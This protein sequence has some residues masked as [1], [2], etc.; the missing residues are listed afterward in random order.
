MTAPSTTTGRLRLSGAPR[1]RGRV[2]GEELRAEI[3]SGM[4]RWKATLAAALPIPIDAYLDRFVAETTFLAA[5]EQLTPDLLA[6]VRGIG[7]GADIPFRDIYAYQLMDEEWF[8]RTDLL[9]ERP[10]GAEHCSTLGALRSD[11]TALLAQ[12]MDLPSYYDGTQTLLHL[13]G[14]TAETE[15]MV[16][17]PA[18]LIGTTGC[19]NRGVGVCVNTLGQLAHRRS[20][21]PVA[22]VM[23]LLLESETAADAA[24]T[25]QR[26]PHASGQNFMIAGP[27]ELSDFECSAGGAAQYQAGARIIRHTNHPLAST[28][29]A[30]EPAG[31]D[32]PALTNSRD[33]YGVLERTIEDAADVTPALAQ[34]T[35]SEC[36]VPVSRSADRGGGWMTFGSLVMELSAEPVVHCAPGP[37]HLTAYA[38]WRF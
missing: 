36:D 1:E 37:P 31:D 11:G 22:F 27:E 26:V 9:R 19:N 30:G 7:E 24:T 33:R 3:R 38:T 10:A 16:L 6:E 35:L 4:E 8:F 34:E 28:D 15:L 13:D 32:D 23:R 14:R 17:T 20:G 25:V 12:N 21:L 29:L 5:I 2:H 18:G